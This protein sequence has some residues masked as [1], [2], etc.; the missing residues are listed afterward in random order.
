LIR[1][2]QDAR[3][4]TEPF[5]D[6]SSMLH[7][8]GDEIMGRFTKIVLVA[9]STAALAIMGCGDDASGPSNTSSDEND[10]VF[11]RTDGSRIGFKPEVYVWCGPWE[12]GEIPVPA[13]HIRGWGDGGRYW[14]LRAVL[15]DVEPGESF[16]FPNFFVWNEPVGADIFIADGSN[17]LST[18]QPESHGWIIF[19]KVECGPIG[20]V[21]FS[22]DAVLGSEYHG[23]DSLKVHGGLSAKFL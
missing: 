6:V 13:L 16:E 15:D 5:G 3:L 7:I 12:E 11:E 20:T 2:R 1:E 9:A 23:G 8:E 21:R 14:S 22:I 18:A 4:F 19:E 17:E 10:L